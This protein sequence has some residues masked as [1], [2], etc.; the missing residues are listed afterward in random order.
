MARVAII[1]AGPCGLSQLRAFEQ[2]RKE[3]APK[4]PEMV[5]LREAERLGRPVELHLAHRARRIRRAGARQH[6]PLSLVERPEGVPGILRL[7]VR[8]P[9]RAADPL[10]PAARG[11]LRLHHRAGEEERRAQTHPLLHRRSASS[12]ISD[13]TGKFR[14]TTEDLKSRARRHRRISTMSIVATGHFSIPNVPHFEGVEK[15]PG[16]VH[17][18]PR[19]PR[20]AGIRRQGPARRRRELFGRGHRA[21]VPQIRGEV[22]HHVLAHQAD[23]LP[24]A[25][26][27]GGAPAAAEARGQDGAFQG[28]IEPRR[29][30]PSCCAP[31]TS[32]LSRSCRRSC[33]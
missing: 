13:E 10:L 4:V 20:R 18:R 15:F 16:R 9:F 17:A 32:T 27:H 7:H 1:G 3:A 11:A 2:A 19:F 8:R 14:V 12:S 21:P 23:G 25:E 22:R 31:A 26:G 29:S 6:V 30:T 33:G 28:R 5:L 24:L